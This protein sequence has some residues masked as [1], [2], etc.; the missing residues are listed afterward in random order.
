MNVLIMKINMVYIR[1]VVPVTTFFVRSSVF[2][3]LF[4]WWSRWWFLEDENIVSI[5]N[6]I[7]MSDLKLYS[8]SKDFFQIYNETTLSLY[9]LYLW[10]NK[11]QVIFFTQLVLS[12]VASAVFASVYRY[13]ALDRYKN[14]QGGTKVSFSHR[15]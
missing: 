7:K 4:W 9:S 2:S 11:A 6:S 15:L 12:N 1:N 8:Q 13:H 3:R 14:L 5:F 10:Y